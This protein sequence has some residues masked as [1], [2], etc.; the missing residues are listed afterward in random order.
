MAGIRAR[1]GVDY[2]AVWVGGADEPDEPD[3]IVGLDE[4]AGGDRTDRSA[5]AEIG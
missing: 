3:G 1:Q 2:A 4:L 5:S